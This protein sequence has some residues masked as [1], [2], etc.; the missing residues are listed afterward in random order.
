MKDVVVVVPGIM[1]SVLQKNK[2]DVWAI[3]GRGIWDALKIFGGSV[4][5]L[6]LKD[7]LDNEE[8]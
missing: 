2:K 1:E 7:D 5:D 8:N 3:S 6:A 4:E